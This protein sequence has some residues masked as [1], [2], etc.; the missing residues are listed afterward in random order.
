M[1]ACKSAGRLEASRG[2]QLQ[3]PTGYRPAEQSAHWKV[4]AHL[5]GR[6]PQVTGQAGGQVRM[7][8][9]AKTSAPVSL[10]RQHQQQQCAGVLGRH[11]TN[12]NV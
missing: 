12:Y 2:A 5:C 4:H 1:A 10:G 11:V 3:L 9:G 7:S 8:D 6:H